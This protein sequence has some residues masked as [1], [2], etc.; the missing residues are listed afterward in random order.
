ME[1]PDLT[2]ERGLQVVSTLIVADDLGDFLLSFSQKR[3]TTTF[4]GLHAARHSIS[5]TPLESLNA[6]GYTACRHSTDPDS[7]RLN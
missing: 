1:K 6:R 7:T 2:P 5:Y 4:V 3:L